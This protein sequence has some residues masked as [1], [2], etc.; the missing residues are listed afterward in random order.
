VPYWKVFVERDGA[1]FAFH[2]YPIEDDNGLPQ[3]PKE[4]KELDVPTGL[5]TVILRTKDYC[6]WR[7]AKAGSKDNVFEFDP[8]EA[9]VLAG[10]VTG[11]GAAPAQE[12]TVHC[13]TPLWLPW[14]Y[15]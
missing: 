3:A 14:D 5:R 15:P 7:E 12:A 6:G 9:G 13:N 10:T 4:L 2:T 8:A 11:P 1:V